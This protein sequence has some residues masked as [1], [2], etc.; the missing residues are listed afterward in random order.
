MPQHQSLLFIVED[1]P[2][3]KV[4]LKHFTKFLFSQFSA[5]DSEKQNQILQ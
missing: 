4:L 3:P 1:V 5:Y 2:Y